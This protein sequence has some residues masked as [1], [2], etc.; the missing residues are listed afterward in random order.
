MSAWNAMYGIVARD[1]A[2][3]TRQT[4]RLLGGIARPFMWLLLVGTGYNTIARL[5]SGISY[6]SFV[7]PGIVVMAALF[8]GTLTAI[9][10]VYDREFG[11]LRL[12]LS[13][14]AGVP[15]VLAGRALAATLIGVVQGGIVLA[16]APLVLEVTAAGWLAALAAVVVVS[17]M[18]AVLGLLVA[19]RLRSVENF[20]GIINVVLFPLL[21]LSGALYPTDGMPPL[22]RAIARA[23]PVTYAVDLLRHALGQ[24]AETTAPVAAGAVLGVTLLAFLLTA[25]LFDPEQRFF[26]A[27]PPSGGAGG[28][29]E[30][31]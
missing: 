27:R 10:T 28:S 9:A 30:P 29:Q 26:P 22:L 16:F 20:A 11:M 5:D 31:G 12:M 25:L 23:N 18:S 3:S 8:G 21:F 17:A 15:A 19:A 7:F 2:R 14:P 6:Q 1:L 24:P 4:S 13:S